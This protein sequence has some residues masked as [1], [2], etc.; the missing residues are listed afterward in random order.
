MEKGLKSLNVEYAIKNGIDNLRKS[1]S[2]K[3]PCILLTVTQDFPHWIICYGYDKK[4]KFYYV[5]N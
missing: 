3:N 1:V 5:I 4:T 2:E